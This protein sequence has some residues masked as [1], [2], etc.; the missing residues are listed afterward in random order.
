MTPRTIFS[1]LL[2]ALI[3]PAQEFWQAWRG[4]N[5]E[6]NW[7]IALDMK[8]NIQWY[9]KFLGI[10]LSDLLFAIV[11]FRI[12]D[13][14]R[15]L[16]LASIVF[17]IYAAVNLSFFIINFEHASSALIYTTIGLVSFLVFGWQGIRHALSKNKTRHIVTHKY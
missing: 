7:W 1:L 9:F 2:L 6:V 10:K 16:R 8:L 12:T 4:S 3:F 17:V 15:M 11:I 14:M 13:K 5:R